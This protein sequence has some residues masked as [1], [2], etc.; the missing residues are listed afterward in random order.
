MK[1]PSSSTS[2]EDNQAEGPRQGRG[3]W[4]S[5]RGKEAVRTGEHY[6]SGEE[7]VSQKGELRPRVHNSELSD[8]SFQTPHD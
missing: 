3:G 7:D 2:L 5:A 8:M 1:L 6:P 4:A